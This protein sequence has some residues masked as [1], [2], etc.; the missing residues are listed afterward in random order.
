M[1]S[2]TFDAVSCMEMLEHVPDPFQIIKACAELIKPN[3]L[4]F[5]ST[6]NRNTKAFLQAILAA[7]YILN[8]LPKGTHHYQKFIRPSELTEWARAAGLSLVELKG[9]QY[10]P[11]SGKC[12]LSDNLSVNYLAAFI[13]N[14]N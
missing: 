13:K 8:L 10:H 5:F 11:F 4:V 2:G 14:E 6:I 1:H 9:I 7:E 3:G 12:L